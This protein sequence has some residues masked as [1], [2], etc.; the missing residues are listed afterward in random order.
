[1]QLDHLDCIHWYIL[2][3]S[4]N[5]LSV[6]CFSDGTETLRVVDSEGSEAAWRWWLMVATSCCVYRLEE[7]IP[8]LGSN[9]EAVSKSDLGNKE[10]WHNAHESNDPA[11][12]STCHF[13]YNWSWTFP[14][15]TGKDSV[16]LEDVVIQDCSDT[17]TY[18]VSV[19]SLL[20]CSYRL[21]IPYQNRS[22]CLTSNLTALKCQL[23]HV[24]L[25]LS[26]VFPLESLKQWA[27]KM[28]LHHVLWLRHTS[29]S[30]NLI[31]RT[32]ALPGVAIWGWWEVSAEILMRLLWTQ[33]LSACLIMKKKLRI[34]CGET[35]MKCDCTPSK[36]SC[37][38]GSQ[39]MS[40]MARR[41]QASV[42]GFTCERGAFT[43]T[44]PYTS[45]DIA[46]H[47]AIGVHPAC[48]CWT[49]RCNIDQ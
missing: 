2:G 36:L 34:A 13:E 42:N 19:K 26:I 49:P 21:A 47:V 15:R 35:T 33:R 28:I 27:M 46:Q 12:L 39:L 14:Q 30:P 45:T 25:A 23:H 38:S 22:I 44:R 16:P 41:P 31:V 29:L 4:H 1:M 17:I 3:H 7:Q 20:I 43:R 18:C 5:R 37:A 6:P 48:S 9:F 32:S 10:C 24:W 40:R 8:I 11:T